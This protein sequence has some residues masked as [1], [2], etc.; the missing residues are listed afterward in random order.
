MRLQNDVAAV[1]PSGFMTGGVGKQAKD[2]AEGNKS[3][4]LANGDYNKPI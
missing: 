4:R 3:C 1:K 2:R